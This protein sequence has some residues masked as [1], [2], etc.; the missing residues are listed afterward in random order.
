MIGLLPWIAQYCANEIESVLLNSL[1]KKELWSYQVFGTIFTVRE[2]QV[3]M[4]DTFQCSPSI[5]RIATCKIVRHRATSFPDTNGAC[6]LLSIKCSESTSMSNNIPPWN[7]SH[8]RELMRMQF[9]KYTFF[10]QIVSFI[11]NALFHRYMAGYVIFSEKN[12]TTL[13]SV[14]LIRCICIYYTSNFNKV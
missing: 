1:L 7:Y 14:V 11:Y 4:D 5:K 8:A 12:T 2:Y 10:L 3:S 9:G 13:R 6:C